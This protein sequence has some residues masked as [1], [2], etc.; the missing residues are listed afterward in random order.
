MALL[1]HW[2]ECI[3]SNFCLNIDNNTGGLDIGGK[4][5]KIELVEY[6]NSNTQAGE[7]AA[8]NRLIFQDKVKYIICAG[9]FEDA[10]LQ[11]AEDNKVVAFNPSLDVNTSLGQKLHYSFNGNGTVDTWVAFIGW[12]VKAHPNE[13]KTLV[14]AFPDNQPGHFIAQAT[15]AMFEA[16][17]VN[18]TNRF[19]PATATDLSVIGT[20]VVSQN[21]ACF[22]VTSISDEDTS[23][24][25]NAVR[26]AGYKGLLFNGSPS[27]VASLKQL[28]S[29]DALD[30]FIGSALGTEFDP[31]TT[32]LGKDFKAAWIA[33]NGNW[34]SPSV[35]WTFAY[36]ALR[37]AL[38]QAGTV[39]SEKVASVISSGLKFD[40]LNGP[41]M[42]ISRSGPG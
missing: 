8:V 41:A 1:T 23:R 18:P 12:F 34:T 13:L 4:K 37:D 32:Q 7:V 39:D 14:R 36:S 30:G 6:D 40:S 9:G 11:T 16:F 21:P 17:G 25:Y 42:M 35:I 24:V 22:N 26:Q 29:P 3:A 38:V 31:P 15:G 19:Y 33:K 10:W 27:T 20:K 5:Y 28:M 2:K